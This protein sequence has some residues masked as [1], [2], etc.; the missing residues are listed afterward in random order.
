MQ[1]GE[2]LPQQVTDG[3]IDR[4]AEG[5]CPPQKLDNS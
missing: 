1:P 4:A 3:V 2:A 5:A